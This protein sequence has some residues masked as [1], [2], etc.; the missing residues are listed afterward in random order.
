M[1]IWYKLI[2][3]GAVLTLPRVY[4]R[5]SIYFLETFQKKVTP[6]MENSFLLVYI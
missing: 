1:V 4:S 2:L 6:I 5:K 3:F